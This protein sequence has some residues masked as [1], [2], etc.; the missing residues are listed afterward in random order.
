MEIRF[1]KVWEF[2]YNTIYMVSSTVGQ[3]T[4]KSNYLQL[5]VRIRIRPGKVI[6]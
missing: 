3:I 1:E 4:L 6:L 2:I 5:L